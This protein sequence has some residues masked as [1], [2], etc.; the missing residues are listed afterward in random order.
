MVNVRSICIAFALI[1]FSLLLNGTAEAQDKPIPIR[2]GWQP[3]SNAPFYVA[4]KAK[5]FEKVGLD[6]TFIKFLS[7]PAMFAAFQSESIDVGELTVSPFVGAIA[8]GVQIVGIAA[9]FNES[10]V[11][12]LLVPADSP[13]KTI[14]DLRG[15]KVAATRGSLSYLGLALDLKN[16][17]MSFEDIVYMNMPVAAIIPAFQHGDIDAAWVW[18]PW[19]QRLQASGGRVIGT[20]PDMA[21]NL[22][23]ARRAWLARNNEAARRFIEALDMGAQMVKRNPELA[24]PEMA[25]ELSIPT[26]MARELKQKVTMPTAEEQIDPLSSSSVVDFKTGDRGL[27]ATVKLTSEFF[28]KEGIIKSFPALDTVFDAGPISSYAKQK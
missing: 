22:W 2:V 12:L 25:Q 21:T 17:N 14:K 19:A 10:K 4:R 23:S 26:E 9:A 6:P 13:A 16:N 24:I 18:S 20:V 28:L 7:G 15:K 3:D 1:A 27:A 5:L 11:N 8:N